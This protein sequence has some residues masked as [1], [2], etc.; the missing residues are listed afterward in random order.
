MRPT[1]R[2]ITAI[3]LSCSA[4]ALGAAIHGPAAA[5]SWPA[6]VIAVE[7]KPNGAVSTKGNLAS[8]KAMPDLAWAAKSSVACFPATKFN[9]FRGNHVL[10]A[11]QI[12]R[13]SEMKITVVPDD[14]KLDLSLYAYEISTSDTTHVVPDL[15]SCVAC[16]AGH[17]QQHES[18]PGQPETVKLVATTNPY[19]VVIGVAGVKGVVSGGYTLKVEMVTKEAGA[20]SANVVPVALDS[21]PND[22]VE[23]SGKLESGGKIDL[24]FASNSS[25]ACWPATENVNFNGNHVLYRTTIP[26]YSE[27]FVEAK[28]TDAKTDLSVYGLMIG[29]TDTKHYPPN[30]PSAV[31]CE[32]GYDQKKDN[33]PGATESLELN[34]TN[35]GY[36]VILGVAGANG[37][38]AGAYTLRVKIVSKQT[39]NV[40]YAD[41]KPIVLD[42]KAGAVVETTGKLESGGKIPLDFASNSSV[43]CWPATENVNFNGHHV[44]YRTTIPPQSEMV[45]TAEPSDPKLDVSV[46][47]LMVGATDTTHY[48]PNVP[49]CVSCEAGYDQKKDS[50]PGAAEKAKLQATTRGYNVIIGVAGANGTT[51]G[52]YKLKVDVHPR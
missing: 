15:P 6:G 14:P 28:P 17:D 22:T 23:V 27:M 2:H 52:A 21:K 42:S 26:P 39:G 25:V 12:P 24:G 18:N 44:L 46:Y 45:V 51:A 4:L 35:H 40:T 19:N 7:A 43:A 33:N 50:N 9:N 47:A 38:T 31:T 3:L 1:H 41:V 20:P 49:S 16:E 11:T 32:A 30:V 36:N 5:G 13:F 37:T 48:P 10:Y 29:A 8:G 34:A